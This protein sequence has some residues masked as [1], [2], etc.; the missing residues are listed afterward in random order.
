M[1]DSNRPRI[2]VLVVEDSSSNREFLIHIL[3]SDQGIEV[4]GTAVN[5]KEAV[6]AVERHKPDVITM[7]IHMPVM[8][9]YEATK[10]IMREY[11][12]PIVIVSG[13][14][15]ANEV[16]ATFRAI[17]AGALAAVQR[18]PGITHAMHA[19]ASEEL[20]RTVK[21]MSEIKV[22]R[23]F[24]R[25]SETSEPAPGIA[26]P[27]S[28]KRKDIEIAAIGASTGG[29]AALMRILSEISKEIPFPILITQHISTGF[30]DGFIKWL[31]EASGFPV[32]IGTDGE[33]PLPGHAYIAPDGFHMGVA[34]GPVIRLS[35]H[36]PEHGLRPS[37]A[38]LFRTAAEEFGPRAVGV[39]LTGMGKD[40]AAEL[41]TM[42]E[43]GAITVAQDSESAVVNG[44]PG[45]AVLLGG[46]TH[47]LPPEKI[48]ELLSSFRGG[49]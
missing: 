33:R 35:N 4:V 20:I 16:S 49:K 42:K 48:A 40:G 12:T 3:S 26:L 47:V 15:K 22:I 44:M 11:P 45:E 25:S 2:K 13:S 5:G 34:A 46:A 17:E 37:V 18:P 27:A 30:M 14:A 39:L 7:D 19:S 31:G 36:P 1:S 6:A 24:A 29:P 9:G 23:R 8:D 21:L 38:F 10:L 43:K 41:K 28:E 32:H